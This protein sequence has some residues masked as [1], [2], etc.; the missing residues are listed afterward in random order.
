MD[1]EALARLGL[2]LEKGVP[3]V[4]DN[5]FATPVLQRPMELGVDVVVHSATKYL[6]GHGDAM[7]RPDRRAGVLRSAPL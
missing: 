3:T 7:G 5:T 2:G 6:C 1:I 4:I